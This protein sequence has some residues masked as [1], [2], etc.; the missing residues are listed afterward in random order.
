VDTIRE[1]LLPSALHCATRSWHVRELL[2]EDTTL[3]I[4]HWTF[5]GVGYLTTADTT[6]ARSAAARAREQQQAARDAA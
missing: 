6:L 4:A 1:N 3:V 2:D 5:V